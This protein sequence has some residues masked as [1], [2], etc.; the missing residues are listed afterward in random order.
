MSYGDHEHLQT[1]HPHLPCVCVY[2]YV[3][4]C[5]CVCVFMSLSL[6]LSLCMYLCYG[7]H[8]QHIT[9]ILLHM[10]STSH[11]HARSRE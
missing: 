1:I 3:C 4:V 10:S 8:E 6:S 5:V 2:L 9:R 7:A 11:A